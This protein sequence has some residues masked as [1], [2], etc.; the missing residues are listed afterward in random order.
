MEGRSLRVCMGAV[1][2]DT[3]NRG[4]IRS[5]FASETAGAGQLCTVT[6]LLLHRRP[7]STANY[8]SNKENLVFLMLKENQMVSLD[9]FRP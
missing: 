4:H 9:T 7:T 2:V 6:G 3:G 5:L 1:E 8:R